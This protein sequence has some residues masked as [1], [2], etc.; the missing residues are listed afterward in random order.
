MASGE[1]FRELTP[2][3]AAEAPESAPIGIGGW[4][5]AFVIHQCLAILLVVRALPVFADLVRDSR[6]L[7]MRLIVIVMA[8]A[9]MVY[10]TAGVVGLRLIARRDKDAPRF[11]VRLLTTAGGAGLMGLFLVFLL[12]PTVAEMSLGETLRSVLPPTVYAFA[13]ASYWSGSERVSRTFGDSAPQ[14]G[15]RPAR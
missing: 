4:L 1:T 7:A 5:L 9:T 6:G 8:L 10:A 15:V 13:W 2:D 3:G 11:H 14:G 12:M